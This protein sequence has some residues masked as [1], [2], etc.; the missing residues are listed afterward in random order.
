[1]QRSG[2][3]AELAGS[4]PTQHNIVPEAG[5]FR[6]LQ[7]CL[8]LRYAA[9]FLSLAVSLEASHGLASPSR[10]GLSRRHAMFGLMLA[11]FGFVLLL[12][13]CS[14]PTVQAGVAQSSTLVA[15]AWRRR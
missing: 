2:Q 12:R 1:M 9:R 10:R 15:M 14:E 7:I 6:F 4:T 3:E 5:W 13:V 8:Q 11:S